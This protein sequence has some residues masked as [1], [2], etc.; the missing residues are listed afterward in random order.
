MVVFLCRLKREEKKTLPDATA[1]HE[2]VA[3]RVREWGTSKKK[4]NHLGGKKRVHA[5]TIHSVGLGPP[6]R[7]C[8]RVYAYNTRG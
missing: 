2:P 3:A 1:E 5:N 4:K 7:H 8:R 6:P